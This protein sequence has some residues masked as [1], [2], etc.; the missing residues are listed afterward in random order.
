MA[1]GVGTRPLP[2]VQGYKRTV[3]VQRGSRSGLQIDD[4]TR[5]R[6]DDGIDLR[7]LRRAIYL[8]Q[9]ATVR[10]MMVRR[11]GTGHHSYLDHSK[12]RVWDNVQSGVSALPFSTVT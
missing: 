4:G 3:Q 1:G 11:L 12:S 7:P 10:S 8:P 5:G 6:H 2:T 9:Q